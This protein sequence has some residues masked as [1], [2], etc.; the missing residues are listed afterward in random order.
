MRED[1]L[2]DAFHQFARN[3]RWGT[4]GDC[5]RS[6]GRAYPEFCTH[7][8]RGDHNLRLHDLTR[9]ADLFF[10]PERKELPQPIAIGIREC[11]DCGQLFVPTGHL[12]DCCPSCREGT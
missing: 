4:C 7:T 2:R 12:P 1:Q 3:F 5:P 8:A 9:Q 10:G 11:E 6:D